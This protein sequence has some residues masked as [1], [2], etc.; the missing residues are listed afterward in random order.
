MIVATLGELLAEFVRLSRNNEPAP[1]SSEAGQFAGPYPSGAPAIFINQ[2]AMMGVQTRLLGAVGNDVFGQAIIDRLVACGTDVGLVTRHDDLPT[3]TA[4]V[5]YNADGSRNYLFHIT[6]TAAGAVDPNGVAPLL[7]GADLLHITGATLADRT[8]RGI[9]LDAVRRAQASSIKISFDPNVRPELMH[10]KA[11]EALMDCL[12]AADWIT[13]SDEDLSAL[14]PQRDVEETAAELASDGR[15]V[16]ITYG[17][18][19]AA[20]FIKGDRVAKSGHRVETIDPTGAGDAF[21]AAFAVSMLGGRS[22]AKAL[23]VATSAG[24]LATTKLGPMEGNAVLDAILRLAE[25]SFGS[26]A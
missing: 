22:P 18:E 20:L 16:V 17:A 4:H 6:A 21:A 7:N 2:A 3:G 10:G 13:P 15:L 8:L 9:A 24:A 23:T 1:L 14:F 5:G 25:D 11:R 12:A 19:G 26:A